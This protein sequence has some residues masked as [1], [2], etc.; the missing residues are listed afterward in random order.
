V[1]LQHLADPDTLK[2]HFL[3]GSSGKL[4]TNGRVGIG[5]TVP[6]QALDVSGS[7]TTTDKGNITVGNAKQIG[8]TNGTDGEIAGNKALYLFN[9][10]STLKL[11]A[12][13]YGLVTPLNFNLGGN[14]GHV[15]VDGGGKGAFRVS[16]LT[17]TQRDAMTPENGMIIYNT[18]TN[19]FNF[20]ENGAW[21]TK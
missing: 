9:N 10:G 4:T 13:D 18:T 8:A 19:Q 6:K 15:R 21:V 7:I 2:F 14:G 17:T 11:D 3:A 1:L 12:Y 20:Y 5:T 16:Q